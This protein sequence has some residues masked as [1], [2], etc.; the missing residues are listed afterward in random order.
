VNET[1]SS[2]H[3]RKEDSELGKEKKGMNYFI[4]FHFVVNKYRI[5]M[6]D[7]E[8]YNAKLGFW[9]PKKT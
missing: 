2:C 4:S 8:A 1:V 3:R 7:M 5:K 6:G 9:D